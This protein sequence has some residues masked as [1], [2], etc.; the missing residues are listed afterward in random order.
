MPQ[1]DDDPVTPTDAFQHIR[2][3]PVVECPAAGTAQGMVFHRYLVLVEIFVFKISPSPL[4]VV[5]VAQRPGTHRR[6]AYQE[7]HGVVSP[8]AGAGYR[9]NG[10]CQVQAVERIVNDMV[11]V[12][13]R[14]CYFMLG[15]H[16]LSGGSRQQQ[17]KRGKK[18]L[19]IHLKLI[20]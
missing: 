2:P 12:F 14:C 7:Q 13:H 16:L 10:T 15:I 1:F 19:C 20:L 9:T 18:L 11:H 8:T 3:Q 5:A 17:A 6:V 4:T